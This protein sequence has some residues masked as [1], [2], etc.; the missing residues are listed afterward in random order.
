MAAE[1]KIGIEMNFSRSHSIISI[2]EQMFQQLSHDR[3]PNAG[4]KVNIVLILARNAFL[5]LN[6]CRKII[7]TA[8]AR[9]QTK[10]VVDHLDTIDPLMGN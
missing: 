7:H 8:E 4:D 6:S 2:R 9:F 5:R 3:G 10:A 1:T